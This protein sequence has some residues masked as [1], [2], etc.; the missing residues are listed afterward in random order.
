V[1]DFLFSR[2][3]KTIDFRSKDVFQSLNGALNSVD[4]LIQL[5]T[6]GYVILPF[7]SESEV[8]LLNQKL[9][10]FTASIAE[11]LNNV[12]YT[13]GRD[14]VKY[15]SL[16]KNLTWPIISPLLDRIVVPDI[17]DCEGCA[18]L[19]KAP[20]EKS[21][22]NSHQ[23]SSLIDETR[24]AAFYG[25]V[26]IQDTNVENGCMHAIPGSHL[27]GNH[28]RSLDVPW[29]FEPY[30]E[31]LFKYSQPLEMK[32]GEI[33]LFDTALIHGSYPNNSKSIRAALNLF[34]KP[35][36]A[37]MM[38]YAKFDDTSTAKIETYKIDADFFLKEEYRNRP[39]N[40]EMYP[41]QG[42]VDQIDLRLTEK[43]IIKMCKSTR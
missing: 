4:S 15:R 12:F 18:W 21:L 5:K 13:S 7:L 36:A 42:L 37:N 40:Q 11:P 10:E 38:H 23:D 17:L 26:A 29:I 25:W 2:K 8:D 1:I 6:K 31:L 24:F 39:T 9:V 34:F 43:K 14:N 41:F 33:L 22:L 35:K 32:A 27:W 16:A 28:Y 30:T 20:G 3:G 19:L